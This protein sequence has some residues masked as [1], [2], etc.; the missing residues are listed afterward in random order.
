MESSISS[1]RSS[2][3]RLD[4]RDLVEANRLHRRRMVEASSSGRD[5]KCL[6]SETE[7]VRRREA[8]CNSARKHARQQ[9]MC[10]QQRQLTGLV[11]ARQH[12]KDSKRLSPATQASREHLAEL[13]AMK[14]QVLSETLGQSGSSW[15][16]Q[17]WPAGS[18]GNSIASTAASRRGRSPRVSDK[19]LLDGIAQAFVRE[20]CKRS[21]GYVPEFDL[22]CLDPLEASRRH[23]ESEKRRF[24]PET[25]DERY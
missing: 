22:D 8:Q 21:A 3:T 24:V 1:M 6:S 16:A 19:K 13:S 20:S 23:I 9:A 12:G 15:R 18:A 5:V 4:P 10:A 14:A 11:S 7:A 17:S 25:L 2:S